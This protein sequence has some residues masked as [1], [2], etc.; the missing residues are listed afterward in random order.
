MVNKLHQAISSIEEFGQSYEKFFKQLQ[1]EQYSLSSIRM[2]CGHLVHIS[3][4]FRK[5]PEHLCGKEFHD[6]LSLLESKRSYSSFKLAV[7]S[8]RYYFRI[9]GFPLSTRVLPRL[10]NHKTLPVVLSQEEVRRFLRSCSDLRSKFLFALIYSC[11]LRLGEDLDPEP[12]DIDKDHMQVH[13]RQS[14]KTGKRKVSDWQVYLF[15]KAPGKEKTRE[16]NRQ[17][18]HRKTR[19]E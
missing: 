12:G 2:Y 11:G 13:I 17:Q 16:G 14:K 3:L 8:L 19:N 10:R 18:E 4:H 7:H 1:V 6:Y 15:T 9:M 5:L